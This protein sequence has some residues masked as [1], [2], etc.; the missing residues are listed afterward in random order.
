MRRTRQRGRCFWY[1]AHET[2]HFDHDDQFRLCNVRTKCV[3]SLYHAKGIMHYF[4]D[5][6]LT[7]VAAPPLWLVLSNPH[8]V[9]HIEC[10]YLSKAAFLS[11]SNSCTRLAICFLSSVFISVAFSSLLAISANRCFSC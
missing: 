2:A 5:L 1:K 4:T 8:Y 7:C 10:I 11:S 3:I 6:E 9:A